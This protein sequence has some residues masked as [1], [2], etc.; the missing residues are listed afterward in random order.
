MP[1]KDL[2][3][4][5]SGHITED[6]DLLGSVGVEFLACSAHRV[7]GLLQPGFYVA[8]TF[9]CCMQLAEGQQLYA[10]WGKTKF[11]TDEDYNHPGFAELYIMKQWMDR[12]ASTCPCM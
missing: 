10:N 1:F 8:R 3:I 4:A 7:Q 5:P 6:P 2:N 9:S 11:W 12:W